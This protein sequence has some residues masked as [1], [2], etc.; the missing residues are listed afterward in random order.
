MKN[1]FSEMFGF[2]KRELNGLTLLM[3]IILLVTVIPYAYRYY[4]NFQPSENPRE[5]EALQKIVLVDR[6]QKKSYRDFQ[7]DFDKPK[8]EKL[9][10]YYQF[11]PN[12]IDVTVWQDFG[13]S[14]KQAMSIVNYV[15]K[16]GKFRKPDDLKRMYTISPEK[17]EALL[18]YVEIHQTEKV[19]ASADKFKLEKKAAIVVEINTADTLQLDKIRGVG[20]SFARR[21]VKYRERLGGFH[22]KEQLMEVFGIDSVKFSEIKDQVRIDVDAIKKININTAEFETLKQH[23]YLKYKEM[24]AIIQYRK[25]H[26]PYKS[27]ADLRKIVILS[28]QTIDKIAPYLIF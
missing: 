17:Y 27:T 26:G 21:I 22:A 7:D 19:Y 3:F 1:R 12:E 13:L 9:V 5:K 28:P 15:K 16:G 4:A 10:K 20:A 18:P 6:Y 2:S 23:P 11:D 24:N 8:A 25:Q 14:Y